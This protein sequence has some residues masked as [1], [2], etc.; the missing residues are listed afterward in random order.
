MAV[1]RSVLAESTITRLQVQAPA[2]VVRISAEGAGEEVSGAALICPDRLPP[3]ATVERVSAALVGRPLA[4]RASGAISAPPRPEATR[5]R[6][7][8]HRALGPLVEGAAAAPL[9]GDRRLPHG[10]PG[11]SLGHGRCDSGRPKRWPRDGPGA[12]RWRDPP[13]AGC[14]P[15]PGA[16]CMEAFPPAATGPGRRGHRALG[17]LGGPRRRRPCT[18]RSAADLIRVRI[19]DVGGITGSPAPPRINCEIDPDDDN[20]GFAAA[21]L[22]GALSL[23]RGRLRLGRRRGRSGGWPFVTATAATGS[24]APPRPDRHARRPQPRRCGQPLQVVVL[25]MQG[26]VRAVRDA[27]RPKTS[28]CSTEAFPPAA[29]WRRWRSAARSTTRA[30]IW[31]KFEDPLPGADGEAL[32]PLAAEL[33]TPVLATVG[34]ADAARQAA[35]HLSRQSADLIRPAFRTH[36]AGVVRDRG[37]TE[38]LKIARA[39]EAFGVNC[40]ID[41]DDGERRFRRGRPHGRPAQRHVPAGP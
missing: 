13:C 21:G 36:A 5:R 27:V 15:R 18:R 24:W 32:G 11:L 28:R 6:P 40:E 37:I 35:A 3:E 30:T 2:G 17:S 33:D 8:G 12:P 22:M 41:P 38:A 39:A 34:G 1:D 29:T 23:G 16:T 4:D 14:G 10:D 19:P 9:P 26:R 7:R 31:P 20:G 25:R